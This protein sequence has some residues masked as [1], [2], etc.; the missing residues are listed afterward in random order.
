MWWRNLLRLLNGPGPAGPRDAGSA[1]VARWDNAYALFNEVDGTLPG[2]GAECLAT[3]RVVD[4]AI[5]EMW[6][7]E[8]QMALHFGGGDRSEPV[9]WPWMRAQAALA[10]PRARHLLPGPTVDVRVG[11]AA[12]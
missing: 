12:G 9:V 8:R 7:A 3:I 11:R 10:E 1:A 4:W 6:A 5:A 2:R